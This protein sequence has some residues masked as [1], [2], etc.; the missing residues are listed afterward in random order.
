M[1]QWAKRELQMNRMIE[2]TAG[3]Y[4]D[5]QGISGQNVPEIE[6]LSFSGLESEN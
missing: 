2:A 4:G 6:G 3:M 1:R 5:L